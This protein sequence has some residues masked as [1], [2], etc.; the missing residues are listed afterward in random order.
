MSSFIVVAY[1]TVGTLYEARAKI[2]ERS[3]E[4]NR[5]PYHIEGVPNL[6][7]WLKNTNFKPTFIK[8]M[9]QKFD[10][11]IVYVDVDAEFLQHPIL[12]EE[13]G[14]DSDCN[15][16]VHLFDRS[17]YVNSVGGFEVLSGTIFLRNCDWVKGIVNE[18]EARCQKHLHGEV[19]Q[20]S[21]EHVLRG[22][23]TEL[24]G[25]Y[26]KIFDREPEVTEP[27][28]VHYQASREVRRKRGR[29]I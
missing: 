20:K 26:C 11:N 17:C 6:G 27:V 22:R 24:P 1:F 9:L 28:I 23:F 5:V 15:I 18:W 13:L 4:R 29:L 8:S 21:L 25:E 12:F 3:L 7:S 14:N 2:L 19:D 16:A 10:E